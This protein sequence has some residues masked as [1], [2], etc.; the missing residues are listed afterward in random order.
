[1]SV[2]NTVIQAQHHSQ[3]EGV[4]PVSSP[5]RFP[6]GTPLEIMED[7]TFDALANE[8]RRKLL[9]ALLDENPQDAAVD[10]S[11]AVNTGA[12]KPNHRLQTAMYHSH[13]PKLVDYGFIEWN[14][15]TQEI[16]KGPQFGAVRHCSNGSTRTPKADRLW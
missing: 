7:T 5:V 1:V 2:H 14:R 12:L 9:V 3:I 11:E 16:V 6:L 4:K 13:L 15:D 10:A 8:D